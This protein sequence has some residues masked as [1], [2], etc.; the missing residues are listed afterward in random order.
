LPFSGRGEVS[1]PA[2]SARLQVASVL[3]ASRFRSDVTVFRLNARPRRQT[4]SEAAFRRNTAERVY[5]IGA[6]AQSLR[7]V[8]HTLSPSKAPAHDGRDAPGDQFPSRSTWTSETVERRETCMNRG[9]E[10][11]W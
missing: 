3:Q 10:A 6:H 8:P 5:T 9:V 4:G 1:P 7:P 11:K 2:S